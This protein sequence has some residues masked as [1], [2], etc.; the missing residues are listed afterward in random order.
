MRSRLFSILAA[1]SLLL[2]LVVTVLPRLGLNWSWRQ[3][4]RI[5]YCFVSTSR[6]FRWSREEFFRREELGYAAPTY[7][8]LPGIGTDEPLRF[9]D[10][11][12][13]HG[14]RWLGVSVVD[15]D[16][17]H[18][19]GGPPFSPVPPLVKRMRVIEVPLAYMNVPLLL[20]PSMWLRMKYR[21]WRR[22]QLE[23]RRHL[24]G[25]CT[26]CGYDLCGTPERCPECGTTVG[27]R[28]PEQ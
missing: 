21:V 13:F 23:A 19:P 15:L 18:A 27:Q 9:H 6:G 20:L 28:M 10:P 24:A 2:F 22:R 3:D 17:P 26:T 1:V 7:R 16:L 8:E 4:S 14:R 12:R 25:L 5:E 11:Y